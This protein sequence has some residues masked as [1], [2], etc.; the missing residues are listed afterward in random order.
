VT[1][2]A[3]VDRSS[4]E[5]LEFAWLREAVMPVSA[6]GE[7]VFERLRCFVPGQEANAQARAQR[8]ASLA[9]RADVERLDAVRDVLRGAPDANGAIARASMGDVLED[10]Q[11]LELQRFCDAAQRVDALLA[12]TDAVLPVAGDAV[13]TVARTLE[14]GRSG[15]FGFYLDGTFDALLAGCRDGLARAQAEFDASRGRALSEI[16]RSLGRDEVSGDEFIVMRTDLRGALPAG[17]RVVREAPTYVLC[18]VEYDEPTL[19]AL[20]RR[21]AAFDALA[22]AE[23]RVRAAL[24]AAVRSRAAELDASAQALGEID[25]LVAAARYALQYD[26]TVAEIVGEPVLEFSA[27]RLLPLHAQLAAQGRAFTPVDV[28][29]RDVAVL[30]GPNMGG[31]SVCLQTCGFI[32]LCASLGLPVPARSARV[33]LF[34]EIAWLGIGADREP[35][36]LLSSF[37]QEVVRLRDVLARGAARLLILVDEFARTTTPHEGGALLVAVL[38]ALRARGACGMLATHLAGIARQAGVRHFAVRGLQDIP[39]RSATERL[40]EALAALAA[41]MDYTIVEVTDDRARSSDA[42]ALAELLG[43]DE[44]IV[45]DARRALSPSPRN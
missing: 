42:L 5:V 37:A 3:I 13:H 35:G 7:R 18:A 10:A 21:D 26:C 41:S 15:K 28:A 44:A 32:A 31:K 33:G 6:Y 22:E 40:D 19:T 2:E 9:A 36:G 24:S 17:V 45:A 38:H 14:P 12:G 8:I 43:L 11:L 29:L 23:E 20:A 16:A 34:D 39:Q 25:V 1:G 27:G 4:A 30:T